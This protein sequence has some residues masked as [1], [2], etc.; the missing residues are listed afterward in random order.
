MEVR[1]LKITNAR[2]EDD[3]TPHAKV[4]LADT[5]EDIS[6]RTPLAVV[7]RLLL[8]WR[9][10]RPVKVWLFLLDENGHVFLSGDRIAKEP[11]LAEVVEVVLA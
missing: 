8:S 6:A 7:S 4:L 9:S 1:R 10:K 3:W 11:A 5:G 2:T